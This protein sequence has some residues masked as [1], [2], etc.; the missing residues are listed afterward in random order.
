M[1]TRLALTLAATAATL[2]A[3]PAHAAIYQVCNARLTDAV[4]GDNAYC[5]TQGPALANNSV[6]VRRIVT[7]EV[8]AGAVDA[9]LDCD[10]Y[11]HR[12]AIVSGPQPVQLTALGGN[13]C[14][15]RLVA[16]EDHTSAVADNAFSF[17]VN[18]E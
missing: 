8:A 4:T 17:V 13:S 9:Y 5:Y 7:V 15:V 12:S 3:V 6:Y 1:R 2:A 14:T 18:V 11:I 16:R 10:G